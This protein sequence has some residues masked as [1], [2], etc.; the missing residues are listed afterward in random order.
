M[1][2][3]PSIANYD[4]GIMIA[5]HHA[6]EILP[7]ALFICLFLFSNMYFS[8]LYKKFMIF[9]TFIPTLF[10][11]PHSLEEYLGIKEK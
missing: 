7:F 5:D 2:Q 4:N 9:K 1:G 10:F 11:F 3:K 8:P 6:W